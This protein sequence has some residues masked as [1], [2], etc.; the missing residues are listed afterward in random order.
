MKR[1]FLAQW[2]IKQAMSQHPF[3]PETYSAAREALL[4]RI[5]RGLEADSRFVAAWLIGSYG[6]GE[7]DAV[8]DLDLVV[9]VDDAHCQELCERGS[10]VHAGSVPARLA[11]FERYGE[12]VNIHENHFNAQEGATFS[13]VFYRDPPVLVDWG[14]VPAGLARRAAQSRLLF[15]LVEFPIAD[16]DPILTLEA[17]AHKI[18]ERAAFFWMMAAVTAKYIVRGR[19]VDVQSFLLQLAWT[20]EEIEDW[21][22]NAGEPVSQ[23]LYPTHVEQVE[24]LREL[25]ERVEALGVPAEPRAQVEAILSV[26]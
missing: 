2:S 14:F 7:Q 25:C 19:D 24:R 18:D 5:A 1:V 16:P 9:V 12:P 11:V 15:S 13:S 17:R 4:D 21:L 22:E 23:T 8:S 10:M 26:E 3:T 6:R 20:V